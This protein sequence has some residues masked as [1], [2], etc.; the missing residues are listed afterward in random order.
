MPPRRGFSKGRI[1]LLQI[2]RSYGAADSPIRPSPAC[3]PFSGHGLSF[4]HYA[5]WQNSFRKLTQLLRWLRSEVRRHDHTNP[6]RKVSPATYFVGMYGGLEHHCDGGRGGGV[7]RWSLVFRLLM[8]LTTSR[9]AA[10]GSAT[11][12]TIPVMYPIRNAA[13]LAEEK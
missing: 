10:I 11:P 12:V 2:G 7:V 13:D 9:T 6:L 4:R 3:D 5:T 8:A 1:R